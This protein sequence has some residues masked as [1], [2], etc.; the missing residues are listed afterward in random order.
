M[1]RTFWP[2]LLLAAAGA[3]TSVSPFQAIRIEG[4][5]LQNQT[6]RPL[7]DIIL[8]VENSQE[9]AACAHIPAGSSFSTRFPSRRYQGSPARVTWKHQGRRWESKK[10]SIKP[11]DD[12][13][14]DKPVKV[15]IVFF[16]N[17]LL[18]YQMIP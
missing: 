11:P 1:N 8:V 9:F 10:F 14:P 18:D 6:G 4:L 3:C 15:L 7:E 12:L 2:C 16:E 13:I 17:G 5:V